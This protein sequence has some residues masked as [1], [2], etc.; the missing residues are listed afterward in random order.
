MRIEADKAVATS[1][2]FEQS[3]EWRFTGHVRITVDTAVLEADTAV[4]TFDHRAAVA[5]AS[6]KGRRPRSPN[7]KLEAAEAR[8]RRREQARL[9]PRRA[10]ITDDE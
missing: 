7:S 5:R 6:S 1:E 3:S 9:R 2:D 8:A 10:Y 4:F